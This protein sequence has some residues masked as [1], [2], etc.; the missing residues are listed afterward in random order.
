MAV[1]RARD[2]PVPVRGVCR[3]GQE[4]ASCRDLLRH[5]TFPFFFSDTEAPGNGTGDRA[6]NYGWGHVRTAV[7]LSNESAGYYPCKSLVE[8]A[9]AMKGLKMDIPSKAELE[10]MWRIS[11]AVSMK[12]AM[13]ERSRRPIKGKA[14]H[15][16]SSVNTLNRLG[17]GKSGSSGS[18]GTGGSVDSE[19]AGG[20]G[21]SD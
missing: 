4:G 11:G 21:G 1:C 9:R 13:I 3:K 12:S 14:G 10:S 8:S 19:G 17:S 20:S 18:S 6:G 7:E 16:A 5:L 2:E 15:S